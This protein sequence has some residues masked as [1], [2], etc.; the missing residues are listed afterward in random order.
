MGLHGLHLKL[1]AITFQSGV[2]YSDTNNVPTLHAAGVVFNDSQS[3]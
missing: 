1:F 2:V 3:R